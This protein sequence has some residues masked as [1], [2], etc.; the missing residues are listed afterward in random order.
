MTA[1]QLRAE[2]EEL[3]D[4]F[5]AAHYGQNYLNFAWRPRGLDRKKT[6]VVVLTVSGESQGGKVKTVTHRLDIYGVVKAWDLIQIIESMRA[7][8]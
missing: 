1:I 6:N 7:E 4:K 3:K 2:L 5:N 8:L